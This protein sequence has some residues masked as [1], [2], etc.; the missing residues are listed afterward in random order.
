[1][2]KEVKRLIFSMTG[3]GRALDFNNEHKIIVEIKA[4]NHRYLD[5]NI[6]MP[7]RFNIFESKIRKKVGNAIS[8]GKLDLYIS[9]ED[10]KQKANTLRYNYDIAK[11]YYEASQ[12]IQKD[13]K[14]V[15][16]LKANHLLNL[17][18]VITIE[19]NIE[20]EDRIWALLEPVLDRAVIEFNK[21]RRIEGENL[22]EDLL[23]KLD[24]MKEQVAYIQ[25][26]SPLLIDEYKNRLESKV[27]DLLNS[28]SFDENRILTEVTIYAD[29]ICIDEEI[30]RLASHISAVKN[31]LTSGTSVGRKLDFIA[32]EM[33]R[34]SNT[35]LSKS[36][37]IDIADRAI[38]LKTE[39][40]KLREQIQNLE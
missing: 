18:E 31:E 22:K 23:L 14:L 4:V 24:F 19:E 17:P 1:M 28:N 15:N 35:I 32:Q 37:N 38:L 21:S 2:L 39:V 12:Q 16:S 11:I 3:F 34:E 33:N 40:E 9:F 20:D 13:F 36:T 25:K 5:L 8:R 29:K 10:Y 30:V 7:R 27:K 26:K 6:K